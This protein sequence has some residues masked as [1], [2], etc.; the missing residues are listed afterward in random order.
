MIIDAEK[1]KGAKVTIPIAG[2]VACIIFAWNASVNFTD[3]KESVTTDAELE[4]YQSANEEEYSEIQSDVSRNTRGVSIND[5]R[6][7]ILEILITG[8]PGD[9]GDLGVKPPDED[10]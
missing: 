3:F 9:F 8:T 4:E 1:L 10:D 7:L 5:K 2:I 6:I